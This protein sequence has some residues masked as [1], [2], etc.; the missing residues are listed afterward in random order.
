MR[1][2]KACPLLF[3]FFLCARRLEG[4][5]LNAPEVVR[6]VLLVSS[7]CD[8]HPTGA[9]TV[10]GGVHDG[11][12]A[13]ASGA[14][15]DKVLK[16]IK[17]KH[18]MT[19][20]DLGGRGLHLAFFEDRRE[21]KVTQIAEAVVRRDLLLIQR[22]VY[23]ALRIDNHDAAVGNVDSLIRCHVGVAVA[24]ASVKRQ[25]RFRE[26][27]LDGVEAVDLELF[28]LAHDHLAVQRPEHAV[29]GRD[30]RPNRQPD[31]VLVDAFEVALRGVCLPDRPC[32]EVE[33]LVVVLADPR[34]QLRDALLS[35]LDAESRGDVPEQVALGDGAC[36]R[37]LGKLRLE[38]TRL[39]SALMIR[40]HDAL[41]RSVDMAP[42][43]LASAR[44]RNTAAV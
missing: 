43:P 28:R 40:F 21:H 44:Q 9:V 25:R 42:F 6:I 36:V 8:C 39:E 4:E 17:S 30:D 33:H 38:A 1:E 27:V 35:P 7:L 26:E 16:D 23:F 41:R 24:E 34:Q 29:G 3:F 10:V 13:Q 5:R 15:Q 22:V 2:H 20:R 12:N 37:R 31:A 14:H 18:D 11:Q 32:R 19:N